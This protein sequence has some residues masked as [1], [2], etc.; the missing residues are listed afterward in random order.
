MYKDNMWGLLG[1][2]QCLEKVG[3]P[4]AVDVKNRYEEAS[5]EADTRPTATCFCAK[6]AGAKS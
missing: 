2:L 6:A 5:A 3:D 4:E 1:L